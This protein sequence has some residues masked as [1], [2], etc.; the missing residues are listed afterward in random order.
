[1][2]VLESEQA[3]AHADALSPDESITAQNWGYAALSRQE[4]AEAER[5]F[6][7][8]ERRDPVSGS[9]AFNLATVYLATNR[10]APAKAKL[11]ESLKLDPTFA[12]A[13]WIRGRVY[14]EEGQLDLAQRDFERFLEIDRRN[15]NA[16]L[17]LS[18]L[19]LQRGAK[20]KARDVIEAALASFP[21]HPELLVLA[22][23]A[24]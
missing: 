11:D 5:H 6:L 19:L 10:L 20:K 21:G 22:T 23:Q 16:S 4:F 24:R 8:A 12:M 3:Y 2:R 1:G 17:E 7:E 14:A 9:V 13:Y 18:R 15:P